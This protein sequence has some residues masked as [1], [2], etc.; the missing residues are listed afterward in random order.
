MIYLN[1]SLYTI[2]NM[3]GV[4]EISFCYWGLIA[5][6]PMQICIKTL[7]QKK[8]SFRCVWTIS[9][10]SHLH[11]GLYVR[12]IYQ[13][14][15]H[16]GNETLLPLHLMFKIFMNWIAI[17]VSIC[18]RPKCMNAWVQ[19][20]VLLPHSQSLLFELFTFSE[21]VLASTVFFKCVKIL[22]IYFSILTI[23]SH[24]VIRYLKKGFLAL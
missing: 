14:I 8:F 22:F 7:H 11:L 23:Y 18:M 16:E 6:S 24:N 15:A 3:E 4:S 21:I 10:R 13:Y 17:I 12:I 20:D 2:A 1:I 19:I 5:V 9:P